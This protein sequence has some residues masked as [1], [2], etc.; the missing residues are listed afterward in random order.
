MLDATLHR[1]RVRGIQLN[2]TLG[3]VWHPG[4]TLSNA[5][6]AMLDT[7]RQHADPIAR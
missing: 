2:R 3:L 4:R 1:L 7:C 5:A 6:T